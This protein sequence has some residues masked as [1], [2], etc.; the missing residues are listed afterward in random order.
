MNIP[1]IA[2]RYN[3]EQTDTYAGLTVYKVTERLTQDE[4]HCETCQCSM[5]LN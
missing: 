2:Q 1:A 4:R 5:E 3:V